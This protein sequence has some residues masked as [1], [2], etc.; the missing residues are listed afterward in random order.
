M[1][2]IMTKPEMKSTKRRRLFGLTVLVCAMSFSG[3]A[4]AQTA[5]YPLSGNLRLEAGGATPF[6][7]PVGVIPIDFGPRPDGPVIAVPSATVMQV[8]LVPKKMMFNPGVLGVAP[9]PNTLPIYPFNSK[10]FQISSSLGV[11]WPKANATF[12]AGG[13]TGAATVTFCPGQSVPSSGNPACASPSAGPG[14]HGLLRY[15]KTANQFG[16]PGI[17]HVFGGAGEWLVGGSPAPCSGPPSCI[18]GKA[19][20]TPAASFGAGAPFSFS[21]MSTR[22][23]TPNL[24]FVSATAAGRITNVI[25]PIGSGLTNDLTSNGGPWTTGMI[26]VSVTQA[27]PQPHIVMLTGSDARSAYGVGSISLV[28]GGMAVRMLE[29]P[30]A[31]RGWLNLT[32]PEPRIAAGMAAACAALFGFQGWKTRRRK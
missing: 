24:F 23:T 27:L 16:G 20:R 12:S 8:G 22:R 7:A 14:Q 31:T 9:I 4:H 28:S 10:Y 5:T 29:G 6:T 11:T 15:V 13:R 30:S 3:L 17:A 1:M 32:V 19:L 25:S 2:Q 21:R 18:G 26:T